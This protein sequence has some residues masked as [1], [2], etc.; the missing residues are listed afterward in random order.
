VG[1]GGG[2]GGGREKRTNAL[3]AEYNVFLSPPLIAD[4]PCR[5]LAAPLE[6]AAPRE[7][8]IPRFRTAAPGVCARA[9]SNRRSRE[10]RA[11]REQVLSK[12]ANQVDNPQSKSPWPLVGYAF[13]QASSRVLTR[14]QRA[15]GTI[16]LIVARPR[17]FNQ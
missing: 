13:N 11:G 3:T 7:A 10:Q 5:V 14:Q 9:F 12:P 17:P 1:W 6:G 16:S 8:A 2:G 15:R 4:P